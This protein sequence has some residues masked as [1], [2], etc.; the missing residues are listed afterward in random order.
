MRFK[1]YYQEKNVVE[2][3]DKLRER[4]GKASIIRRL[5]LNFVHLLT[6]K[7]NLKILEIGVG[8]GHISKLL[9][10]KGDFTG[11]DIS[12][13]MLRKIKEKLGNVN[14]I[15]GDILNLKLKEKYDLITTI[16]VISHFNQIDAIKALRNINK[17][18]VEGGQVVFNLENKSLTRRIIRKLRNWGSTYTYQYSKKEVKKIAKDSDLKIR[19]VYYLDHSFIFPLHILNKLLFNHLAKF[20]FKIE[21]K[22][23]KVPFMFNNYFIRCQK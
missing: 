13:E 16:R 21:L 9:V 8:T 3:Y 10:K 5:E 20:I 4:K 11:L 19:K 1:E 14:L 6:K 22:L 23:R 17:N 12:K 7:E 2:S 18:L 15:Q